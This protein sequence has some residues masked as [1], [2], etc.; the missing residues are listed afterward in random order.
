M[1]CR[2]R[3]VQRHPQSHQPTRDS[4]SQEDARRIS[5]TKAALPVSH[6]RSRHTC[7]PAAALTR[8]HNDLGL[9]WR[10]NSAYANYF[11]NVGCS[12]TRPGPMM[13][14]SSS[15]TVNMGTG[16]LARPAIACTAA[17]PC[18]WKIGCKLKVSYLGQDSN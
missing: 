10:K 5:R 18:A 11:C 6:S 9:W 8:S 3:I 14:K 4:Q 1:R 13:E 17:D 7:P 12:H 2:S 15:E 16:R